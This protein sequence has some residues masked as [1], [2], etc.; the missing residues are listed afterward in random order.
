MKQTWELTAIDTLFF[1]ES[2]PMEAPGSSE[3]VSLFP[4]STRTLAGAI[5]S[6]IGESMGVSWKAFHHDENDPVRD[7]IG[8]GDDFSEQLQFNGIWV[9]YQGERLYPAPLNLMVKQNDKQ[10]RTKI[11]Q[12]DFIYIG[13][14]C[15]CDLGEKVHLPCLP[16]RMVGSKP[17]N[18]HWLTHAGL[19][20]VLRGETPDRNTDII[21]RKQLL[22]E[23]QRLGIARDN[24]TRRV[25]EGM[26]YQT[27]HIRFKK[28]TALS[29]DVTIKKD[30][31]KAGLIKLGGEGR[32]ASLQL[33]KQAPVFPTSPTQG[34]DSCKGII[35]YLLT[36]L[37]LPENTVENLTFLPNFE[38]KET[39][40]GTVWQGSLNDV[41]LILVSSII[42]KAQ[43]EGGWD[44]AKHAPVPVRDLI[45]AGS[46][47]Y[48]ELKDP[49]TTTI[50]QA[51]TALH[52]T[53]SGKEQH[54]GRGHMAVGLW[55]D[56]ATKGVNT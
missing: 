1:R 10:Q 29:V 37:L 49:S 27:R 38:K 48:C 50:Q 6:H 24:Q 46:V 19:Q 36:P 5:R 15:E 28:D 33:L 11:T 2:R 54:L 44:M 16:E 3:L 56:A 34:L 40:Q 9:H 25:K 51:I 35:L 31:L 12:I 14:P 4:P 39:E 17:L 41:S 45:P 7:A 42:G 55:Q 18:N 23:E 26:L 22:K 32:M 52:D 53:Q 13:I 47:F 30:D 43:R 20:K 21:S 8:Y